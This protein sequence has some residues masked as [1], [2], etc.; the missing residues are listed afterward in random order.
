MDKESVQSSVLL[1]L[2]KGGDALHK[3]NWKQS[4]DAE[5]AADIGK[6]RTYKGDSVR[7][8]LRAFRNKVIIVVSSQNSNCA[9]L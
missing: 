8:L 3:D 5:I 6:Y 4:I 1:E 7:D 2:E 9:L